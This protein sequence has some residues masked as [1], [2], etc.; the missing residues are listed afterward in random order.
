MTAPRGFQGPAPSPARL[1]VGVFFLLLFAASTSER[2]AIPSGHHSLTHQRFGSSGYGA[3][4]DVQ[5][6]DHLVSHTGEG[7]LQIVATN[8]KIE[9]LLLWSK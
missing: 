1:S 8:K 7:V 3:G 6:P 9:K 2:C 5:R 4:G